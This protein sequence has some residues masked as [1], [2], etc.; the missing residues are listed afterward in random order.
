MVSSILADLNWWG[1]ALIVTRLLRSTLW[2]MHI[3]PPTRGDTSSR[4]LHSLDF[5][6]LHVDDFQHHCRDSV[7]TAPVECEIS[8]RQESQ[9][10]G[11]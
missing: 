8:L 7:L 6:S 3:R 4:S 1:T 5:H 2:F 11:T 10:S 9:L